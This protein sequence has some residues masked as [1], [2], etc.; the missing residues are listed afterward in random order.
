MSTKDEGRH[1]IPFATVLQQVAKGTAHN[2]LSELLA[3]LAAAVHEHQKPG[4]LTIV[5]KVEPTK[6]TETLTVSVTPAVKAPRATEASIFFADDAGN[7]T[8]HDPRQTAANLEAV[9]TARR[10]ETA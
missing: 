4:T 3:D 9:G 1:I 6:G 7:L 10:G 8:R 5:V 2:E